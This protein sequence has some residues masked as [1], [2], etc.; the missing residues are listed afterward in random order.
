[1]SLLHLDKP[2]QKFHQ[3]QPHSQ[4]LPAVITCMTLHA[5]VDCS[6]VHL[7]TAVTDKVENSIYNSTANQAY[8]QK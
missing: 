1:M 7:F 5:G 2:L 4:A 6:A 8:Q 3:D